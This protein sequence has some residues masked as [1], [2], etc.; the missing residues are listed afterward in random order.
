MLTVTERH[1]LVSV[2]TG[3]SHAPEVL[4][5]AV[6]IRSEC[7]KCGI[8][9]NHKIC[10]R[11]STSSAGGRSCACRKQ[12]SSYLQLIC[13]AQT[14]RCQFCRYKTSSIATSCDRIASLKSYSYVKKDL[15]APLITETKLKTI[16]SLEAP[17]PRSQIRK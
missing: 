10:L 12:L 16:W 6:T 9:C 2:W 4:I 15:L 11:D 5:L 3:G 7:Q 17:K 14:L 13:W 1:C 8:I